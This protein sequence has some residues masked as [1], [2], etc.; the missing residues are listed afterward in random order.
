MVHVL[1]QAQK[2]RQTREEKQWKYE[3]GCI[4]WFYSLSHPMFSEHALVAEYTSLVSP[5]KEVIVEQQWARQLPNPLHIISNIRAMMDSAME[6]PEVFSSPV[7]T[8]ILQCIQSE[9][10]ILQEK[11]VPRRRT[12]S[13]STQ[14]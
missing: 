6:H 4:R 1:T 7:F 3:K 10:N 2:G 9:H 12:R 5:Y 11:P 14:K 8:I 13:Q